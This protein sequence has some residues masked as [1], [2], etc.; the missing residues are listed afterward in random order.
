MFGSEFYGLSFWWMIPLVMI[1]LCVIL[2]IFMMRG[3]MCSMMCRPG[4][5][6]SGSHHADSS[7]S[8]RETLTR[9]YA[10][11]EENKDE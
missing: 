9:R 5:R 2:C 4:S 8:A 11:G 6:N 1:A 7:G 10:Q 3:H